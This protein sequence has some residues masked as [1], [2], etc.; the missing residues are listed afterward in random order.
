[1]GKTANRSNVSTLAIEIMVSEYHFQGKGTRTPWE[2][3]NSRL[4]QEMYKMNPGHLYIL[5]SRGGF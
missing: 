1:M 3:T 4:K 5:D 2:M